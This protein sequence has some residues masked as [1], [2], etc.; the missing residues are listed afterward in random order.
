MCPKENIAS[1]SQ[2]TL[3]TYLKNYHTPD[4]MV[5]AGVG[6]LSVANT[7]ITLSFETYTW[8]NTVHP[9]QMLHQGLHCLPLILPI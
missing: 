3:Y 1:I 5:L 9:D 2:S 7:L 8:A 6:K 4:R